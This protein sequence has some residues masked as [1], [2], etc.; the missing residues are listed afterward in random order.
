M[1]QTLSCYLWHIVQSLEIFGI[2][3]LVISYLVNKQIPR[4]PHHTGSHILLCGGLVQGWWNSHPSCL[5]VIYVL[6]LHATA[7]H[8]LWTCWRR[9][10]QCWSPCDWH[11]L[12]DQWRLDTCLKLHINLTVLLQILCFPVFS[13]R[14]YPGPPTNL[15]WQPHSS[16]GSMSWVWMSLKSPCMALWAYSDLPCLH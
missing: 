14:F 6:H 10:G 11:Q 9:Q 13:R 2:I 5:A 15:N 16:H 8:R 7:L 12:V 3:Y 1:F 4:A